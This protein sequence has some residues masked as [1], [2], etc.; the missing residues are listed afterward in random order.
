VHA[1]RVSAR[2]D[3]RPLELAAGA[4]S[5]AFADPGM[6]RLVHL[7]RR[8][9][10]T[11]LPVLITGETG[12]GK[13]VLARIVHG[14]SPRA[15]GPFVIVNCPA[16]PET[17]AESE[18]FG[19]ARGAFTGADRELPGALELAAGGTVFLDEVA[20]MP[21]AVQAKL[22]RF[23][24]DRLVTPIGARRSTVV[25]VR[26]VAAT[27][28]DLRAD[29]E[30]GRFRVDLY[31]RLS[32]ATLEIPPL[33]D[34]S[35]DVWLLFRRFVADACRRHD[36]PPLAIAPAAVAQLA[37]HD[38]PG[39]VRELHHVA[40]HAV[41]LA[42]GNLLELSH[43]PP[44]LAR[45]SPARFG[46]APVGEH[47]GLGLAQLA[48]PRLKSDVADLERRRIL[49][50]LEQTRGNQTRA[51]RLLGISRMTLSQRLDAYGLPRPRKRP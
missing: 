20:D 33:R 19:H 28:R 32:G 50:A 16:I 10:R 40:E 8:L 25:D 13:E 36:R 4:G 35:A 37:R 21:L 51:A 22:L 23:L 26:V 6:V 11:E 27:N 43:L 15:P 31:H 30:H 48:T 3:H 49:E 44:A 39:N 18:L 17:L 5:A 42:D 47:L 9:A 24:D 12:A 2:D 34:R 1:F 7:A 38:W 46:H 29:I 14:A 45:G 41:A